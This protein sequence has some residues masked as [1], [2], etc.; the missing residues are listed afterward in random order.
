MWTEDFDY[1]D[2]NCFKFS[3][4]PEKILEEGMVGNSGV[5][6]S[7]GF[8]PKLYNEVLAYNLGLIFE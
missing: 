2:P 1:A 7:C 4:L 5:S 6:K 3:N 8:E